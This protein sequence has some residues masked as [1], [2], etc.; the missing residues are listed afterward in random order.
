[1]KKT[2]IAL[3]ATI[4]AGACVFFACSKEEENTAKNGNDKAFEKC[5]EFQEMLGE[6]AVIIGFASFD[7][8]EETHYLFNF[9]EFADFA[10]NQFIEKMGVELFLED[11][12]VEDPKPFGID[13]KIKTEYKI[14]FYNP[15]TDAGATMWFD[16]H[17][18]INEELG[19]I[20]YYVAT[21]G[22]GPDGG[23]GGY[24][25]NFI[26]DMTRDCK[27]ADGYCARITLP[28]CQYCECMQTKYDN[29]IGCNMVATTNTNTEQ[30]F[31][32]KVG[33]ATKDLLKGFLS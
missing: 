21:G 33:K 20:I 17:K 2:M 29:Q 7:N 4:M 22:D 26:C 19:A 15:Q 13:P 12:Q 30:T 3:V 25:A 31:W 6:D 14:S 32:Q 23:T 5:K 24:T 11:F 18:V 8:P 16:L 28:E 27:K 9:E 1:M 10:H